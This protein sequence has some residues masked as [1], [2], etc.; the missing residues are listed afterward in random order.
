MI[1]PPTTTVSST[2]YYVCMYICIMYKLYRAK[3]G[4]EINLPDVGTDRTLHYF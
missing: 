3:G 4:N 2:T 1:W